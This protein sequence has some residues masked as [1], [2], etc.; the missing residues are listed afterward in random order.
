LQRLATLVAEG[1]SPEIVLDAVAAEMERLLVADAVA[2]GR[3]ESDEELTVVAHR[4]PEPELARVGTRL[5]Y[6][7]HNISALVRRTRRPARLEDL[8]QAHG[9]LIDVFRDLGSRVLVGT[10]IVVEGRLWGTIVLS[11][12]SESPPQADTE[13]RM[14]RFAELLGTAIANADMRN[15]LTASRARL[16]T[17]ADEARRRLVRDLHDGAQQRL[18]HTIITLKLARRALLGG[19]GDRRPQELVGEALEQAERSNAELRELA[20]G[21]LPPV[22]TRGGLRAAVD[23]VVE[24]VDLPVEVEMP[25]DR[26]PPELEASAYFV[27]AEALTNVMKHAHASSAKVGA[28]VNE[29]S[30]FIEVRDDGVG[31]ADPNGRGLVGIEDRIT[32]FGG[33][34]RVESPAGGGTLVSATL[35]VSAV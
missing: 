34:L 33:R 19:D 8:G 5:N 26:F 27:I 17:A 22:L 3:Y 30:L 1:A 10:P 4:S 18:V 12:N 14:A 28:S 24:R 23:T 32:A 11:W 25:D 6:P 2:V 13:E 7:G 16:V 29:G 9:G 35:P 21:I 31:G 15:Q 20:H